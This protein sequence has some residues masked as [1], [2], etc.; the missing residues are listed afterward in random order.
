[1][2]YDGDGHRVLSDESVIGNTKLWYL[3]ST[4]LNQPVVE[5][6]S[7]GGIYRAYVYSPGGQQVAQQSYDT[8]FH[9]THTNH[10]GSGYKMTDAAGAVVF[11]EEFDPHGQTA[12][13]VSNNGPWYLSHKF[14]GYERDAGTNTDNAKARQYHHNNGRFMQPD[15]L[16]VLASD[17]SNPQSLNLYSYVQ[18]DP[19]NY[20]DPEGLNLMDPDYWEKNEN[21]FAGGGRGIFSPGIHSFSSYTISTQT[22]FN[23]VGSPIEWGPWVITTYFFAVGG[24]SGGSAKGGGTSGGGSTQSPMMPTSMGPLPAKQAMLNRLRDCYASAK[25]EFAAAEAE[26]K[27]AVNAATFNY[28]SDDKWGI[29]YSTVTGSAGWGIRA[30]KTTR[31]VARVASGALKGSGY[32]F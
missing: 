31:T 21:S 11:R 27:K 14:T 13:R 19:V 28:G 17:P 25:R 24:S 5:L 32:G 20:I 3:W 18:N 30:R 1:M 23:F 26:Y 10:L 12:L 16:S 6:G 7:S 29:R 9:W 22:G 2:E 4:V 15:P 8:G